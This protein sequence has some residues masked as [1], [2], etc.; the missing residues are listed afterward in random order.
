M[1]LAYKEL[2]NVI[3][4]PLQKKKPTKIEY[5]LQLVINLVGLYI[6]N[7]ITVDIWRFLT[8]H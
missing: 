5:A 3:E 6:A 1:R 8:G 2:N 7:S 4:F